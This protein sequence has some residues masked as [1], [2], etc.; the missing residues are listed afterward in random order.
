M[1]KAG[2]G[3]NIEGN[4]ERE[5]KGAFYKLGYNGIL[6][7]WKATDF[8]EIYSVS[9]RGI[10]WSPCILSH[11]P[12]PNKAGKTKTEKKTILEV[13]ERTEKNPVRVINERQASYPWAGQED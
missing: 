2:Q 9:G 7:K 3:E 8:Q 10:P 5:R 4:E 6:F 12:L 1:E 11:M 13:P